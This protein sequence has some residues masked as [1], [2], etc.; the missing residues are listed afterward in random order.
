MNSQRILAFSI[1]LAIAT[2]LS[3]QNQGSQP[4]TAPGQYSAPKEEGPKKPVVIPDRKL[5]DQDKME[6][7]RGLTAEISYAR[8]AFPLGKEGLKLNAETGAITPNREQVEAMIAGYGPS[9]KPGDRAQITNIKFK[10]KSI[11]FELNGGP[12]KKKKWYEHIQVSGMGGTMQP[13]QPDQNQN[14]HGTLVELTFDKFVPDLK[15]EQVKQLLDPLLNFS[16]KSATEAYLDTIPP[17]AK[18][19]I[20]EHKALVGMNRE[21]VIYALGRPPQKYRSEDREQNYEEWIYGTPPQ[22]VKFVRFVGNEVVRIET[23]KVDGTK[24]VQT[25]KEVNLDQNQPEV[26]Q[27][28]AQPGSAPA[29]AQ[30][31]SQPSDNAPQGRPS[32]R[33]PGEDSQGQPEGSDSTRVPRIP[34]PTTDTS[35]PKPP[36]Q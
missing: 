24:V 12:V 9:V 10:S 32:L 30:P 3:A 23:M 28:T 18:E 31:A 1:A 20:K 7:I 21:M 19:A 4:T 6:L 33:R 13:G 16:A 22:E 29:Q 11:V 17:I 2:S 15:T 5:T 25:Q 35:I 34:P 26:A 8:Q 14:L 36:G 27:E